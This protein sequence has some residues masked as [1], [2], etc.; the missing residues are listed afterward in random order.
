MKARQSGLIA[1]LVLT[2]AASGWLAA[3]EEGEAGERPAKEKREAGRA[4]VASRPATGARG[5]LPAI[6]FTVPERRPL[7]AEG[8]EFAAPLS[9]RPPPPAP[10]AAPRPQ[11]PQLPFRFVGVIDDE[12]TRSVLLMEGNRLHVVQSGEQIDGRYRVERI[13]DTAIEFT[14]LPLLQRQTLP[15]ASS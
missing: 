10:V 7:A 12:G 11:A 5:G 8:A 13:G 2:L 6:D 4:V 3:K 15:T 1:A 14:Y 9:F